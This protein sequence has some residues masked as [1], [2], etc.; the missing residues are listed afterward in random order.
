M[1]D[2]FECQKEKLSDEKAMSSMLLNFS[3][4]TF[5]FKHHG[6]N[7]NDWGISGVALGSNSHMTIHTFPEKGHAFVDVFSKKDFEVDLTVASMV[8]AFGARQHELR[9]A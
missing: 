2:C 9:N 6:I 5:I 3:P 7:P 4:K 8:E 1:L